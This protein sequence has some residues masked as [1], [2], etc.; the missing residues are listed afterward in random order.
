M[1]IMYI[2]PYVNDERGLDSSL[3]QSFYGIIALQKYNIEYDY[4]ATT[5]GKLLNE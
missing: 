4:L 1:K 5:N 3:N 2:K